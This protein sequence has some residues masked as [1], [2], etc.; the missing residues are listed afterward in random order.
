MD[1]WIGKNWW[2]LVIILV[3]VIVSLIVTLIVIEKREKKIMEDFKDKVLSAED[4]DEEPV[5]KQPAKVQ[6]KSVAKTATKTL[7][8]TSVAKKE[9]PKKV[10]PKK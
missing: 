4:N 10:E 6:N 8:A 7:V 2:W 1:N 5:V 9:Q 3:V